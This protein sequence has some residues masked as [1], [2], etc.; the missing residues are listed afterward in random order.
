[1]ALVFSKG[2]WITV[3]LPS[4]STSWSFSDKLYYGSVWAFATR[5]KG[6]DAQ[7]ASQIAEAV[8]FQ[9]LYPGIT[10]SADM[11][12]LYQYLYEPLEVSGH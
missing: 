3:P 6:L 4:D 7:R 12:R 5:E 1:M 8:V 11:E 9:R 2:E 10:M